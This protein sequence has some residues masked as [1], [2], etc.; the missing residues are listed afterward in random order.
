MDDLS[1]IE[2]GIISKIINPLNFDGLYHKLWNR[3]KQSFGLSF[4][5]TQLE[6]GFVRAVP[7]PRS[8]EYLQYR[9]LILSEKT[10][11]KLIGDLKYQLLEGIRNTE[12]ITD[13][14]KRLDGIFTGMHDYEIERIARTETLN[15]MAEGRFQ[16][17]VQSGI[18]N[19]KQWKAAMK[20]AR[21]AADSKRL[22]GQIQ[23]IEDPFVDL[24]TGDTCM[25]NPNRSNC[26]CT[27]LYLRKLPPNIIH[28]GGQMY[29]ADEVQKIEFN[30]G[31]LSKSEKKIWVKPTSKR[32]GHY[33]KVKGAEE[34]KIDLR[35]GINNMDLITKDDKVIENIL[36]D[37]N[38]DLKEST[39]FDGI[40]PCRHVVVHAEKGKIYGMSMLRTTGRSVHIGLLEVNPNMR[41]KGYGI[42]VM[43]DIID[44]IIGSE[45]YDKINLVS[46]DDG[47]DKFYDAIGM[48]R[49]NP[50]EDQGEY[51]GDK[52]W[53]KKFVKLISK[54]Q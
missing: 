49:T 36:K 38:W 19:Y 54:K 16:A 18:A 42:K 40:I 44:T 8:L 1:K 53:M 6:Y 15:A 5:S 51:E 46:A 28:K 39:F 32:K 31:S 12:S 13:I 21:T 27:V 23:K 9:Q 47:S 35:D 34:R 45:I 7:D 43:R 26:R 11:E 48:V 10:K 24:K 37:G 41:R 3:V 17:N 22:N 25:H 2:L 33:R 14:K 30:I 29:N 4:H 20:N 50:E 52:E